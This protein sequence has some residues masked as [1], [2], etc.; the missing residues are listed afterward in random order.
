MVFIRSNLILTILSTLLVASAPFVHADY[1]SYDGRVNSDVK[2]DRIIA[3]GEDFAT[4][5]YY[6]S[7]EN[8]DP[9]CSGV[10]CPD[11]T[12][13]WKTG[14]KYCWGG[15]TTTRQYLEGIEIGLCAG[16]KQTW[17]GTSY[18]QCAVGADCSGFVSVAW[19]APRNSTRGFPNIS[20]DID[21][22]NLR[23]GDA[24]NKAGSHIRLFDY[25]IADTG[26]AMLYE[27][28]SGGG[29]LWKNVHRSLARDNQYT[30]IRYNYTYD[31]FDYPEPVIIYIRRTGVERVQIRW[32]GEADTGYRL[33]MSDDGV[34]WLKIRDTADLT[35]QM[36]TCEVSG[37][38]PDIT[39]YFRITSVNNTSETMPSD[40]ASVRISGY[41]S[42]L[43]IVDGADRRRDQSDA[44]HEFLVNAGGSAGSCGTGFDFCSNEAVVDEQVSLQNYH[45][46]VWLLA[47]ESTFDET[48][49]WPEQMH[50]MDFLDNGGNLFV[51][52]SEIAWDLDEKGVSNNYKNGSDNDRNFYQQYLRS[53]YHQD[54]AEEYHVLGV[55]E[56]PFEGLDF[57]FDD[58]THGTYKVE[59]PDVIKSTNGG[60][61]GIRYN[62]VSE[63]AAL[64]YDS[65]VDKG[66]I[67]NMGFGFETVYPASSRNELMKRILDYF[68]P[69]PLAPTIKSVVN[70]APGEITVAWE[71]Y[72]SD[73]FRIYTKVG[74]EGWILQKD[75]SISDTNLRTKT[76]SGFEPESAISFR[77]HSVIRGSESPPSDALSAI[78]K[79]GAPRVLIVDGY[80]R[81]NT[82]SSQSAGNNHE[83]VSSIASSVN[84]A[85]YGCDSCSNEMIALDKLSLSD[86]EMVIW[87]CGEESTESE[88]FSETE[89]EKVR[90]YLESGGS[91]FVSGAEIAWDLVHKGGESNDYSNGSASDAEFCRNYLKADYSSDDAGTYS[92]T[93][94]VGSFLEGITFSFDNG[95]HGTYD[96]DYPDVL[97]TSQ[98]SASCLEY[99]GGA[100]T[101]GVGFKGNFGSSGKTGALVYFGFPV[102]TIYN[103]NQMNQVME[104]IL[105]FLEPKA[106]EVKS[107]L[108]LY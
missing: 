54:D 67:V 79:T 97:E 42:P 51:S 68:S 29:T 16:N 95:S 10:I 8:T 107:C 98:G 44:S 75:A 48:F 74:N 63:G 18:G 64:I 49:S 23:M 89:Q 46:T 39:Y 40:A 70:S 82:Q 60:K 66:S 78:P 80:D 108:A 36:S 81:W 93:G 88:T 1:Y 17:G 58:G 56:T 20:E 34:Q 38:L 3:I 2:R 53:S 76:L 101:A 22:D 26:T 105:N 59:Y 99:N 77:V 72:A 37:L 90:T 25:F 24:L 61:E 69:A 12:T 85:G 62:G 21:W 83:F 71:G 14:M 73:E 106:S 28:T 27:S 31:V 4:L 104:K 94:T 91:L 15:E 100:G 33:Y 84:S 52:G 45:S 92:A 35:P 102:E 5:R 7:Q 47:E 41:S 57:N 19:T 9:S 87:L 103:I 30:P 6:M 96:V 43:L 32:D 65:S 50:A 11:P 86:Y 55:S 13:G